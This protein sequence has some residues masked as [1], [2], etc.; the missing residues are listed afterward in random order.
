MPPIG[1]LER[2]QV[3]GLTATNDMEMEK[4]HLRFGKDEMGSPGFA[5][6]RIDAAE[7]HPIRQVTLRDIRYTFIGG[8]SA[9]GIPA[10]YPQVIDRRITRNG[11]SVENY[12]PNWSRAA[13]ADIRNVKDLALDNI[14]FHCLRP[15]TRPP[16]LTEGCTG[17]FD[18]GIRFLEGK[19]P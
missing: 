8:V 15:D 1:S 2:I 12:W 7:D 4:T 6:I 10:E 14:Q 13:F 11:K 5:G 16:V 18:Q 17:W 9:A 3:C 19:T